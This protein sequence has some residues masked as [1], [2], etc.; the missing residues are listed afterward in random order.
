MT[1]P[2]NLRFASLCRSC[3]IVKYVH[4][5]PLFLAFSANSLLTLT[6]L[7]ADTLAIGVDLTE[8][9]RTDSLEADHHSANRCCD[10]Y[11]RSLGGTTN[12]IAPER[13]PAGEDII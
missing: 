5:L 10:H 2:I 9:I 11:R 12:L 6:I 4:R 8:S 13:P 3:R 1:R 7:A